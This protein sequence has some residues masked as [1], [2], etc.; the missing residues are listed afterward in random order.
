MRQAEVIV[1]KQFAGILTEQN[2][3]H[4][5]F[6]YHDMYQGMPVSLTMPLAQKKFEYTRFP[7]FFD[8]LLPEGIMLS[9]LLKLDKL[10]ANDYFGQLMAVGNDLVGNISVREIKKT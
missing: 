4:Y 8:G 2:N 9:A 10:D 3:K 6:E 7:A 5:V 1:D